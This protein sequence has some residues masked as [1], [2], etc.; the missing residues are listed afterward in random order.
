MNPSHTNDGKVKWQKNSG[1]TYIL[2][3]N[4][5]VYLA[6]P[7]TMVKNV[8]NFSLQDEFTFTKYELWL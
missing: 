5:E 1:K 7:K 2:L 3:E 8:K 4:G 6:I